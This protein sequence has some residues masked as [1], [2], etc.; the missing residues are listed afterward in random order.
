MVTINTQNVTNHITVFHQLSL[1]DDPQHAGA[2]R[3]GKDTV[4]LKAEAALR[5]RLQFGPYHRDDLNTA[6]TAFK[7][8]ATSQGW[9]DL[10]KLY[11]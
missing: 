8:C 1:D 11:R 6:Y 9:C 10:R 4:K 5:A 7:G 3:V 2:R